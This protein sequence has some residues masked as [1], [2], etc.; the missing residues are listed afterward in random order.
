MLRDLDF[1][2]QYVGIVLQEGAFSFTH[3]VVV[4][5]DDG[6]RDPPEWESVIEP[7]PD[8][9]SIRGFFEMDSEEESM[10]DHLIFKKLFA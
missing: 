9:D 8:E 1:Q 3:L 2:I 5:L 7:L 6:P 4:Y 10:K